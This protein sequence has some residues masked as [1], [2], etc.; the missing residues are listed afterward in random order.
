MSAGA[1]RP[2]KCRCGRETWRPEIV[3]GLLFCSTCAFDE[4][5]GTYTSKPGR[6]DAL[7]YYQPK[8]AVKKVS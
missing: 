1:V 5:Y 4:E 6:A 3:R 8:F 7:D 2:Y